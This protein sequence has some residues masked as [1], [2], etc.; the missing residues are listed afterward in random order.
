MVL[1]IFEFLKKIYVALFCGD[2]IFLIVCHI[3]FHLRIENFPYRY[4]VLFLYIFCISFFVSLCLT[5]S[6]SLAREIC[7]NISCLLLNPENGGT[8]CIQQSYVVRVNVSDSFSLCDDV[9]AEITGT[10]SPC[11]AK[12]TISGF[13]DCL[14]RLP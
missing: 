4:I 10:F 12:E 6:L 1:E 7:F 2:F 8:G 11:H 14:P 3:C 13:V 9:I 5:F